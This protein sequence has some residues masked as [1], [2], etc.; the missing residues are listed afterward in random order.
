MGLA[1]L[2][3]MTFKAQALLHGS[4][5]ALSTSSVHFSRLKGLH[6]RSMAQFFCE[7]KLPQRRELSANS[8]NLLH[9]APFRREFAAIF[10]LF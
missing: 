9:E 4:K 2:Q 5:L 3:P 8:S 7:L 6:I 1:K 10:R